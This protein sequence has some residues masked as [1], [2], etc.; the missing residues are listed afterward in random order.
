MKKQIK[1]WWMLVI[2]TI[3]IGLFATI[4]RAET[5]YGDFT[6]VEYVKNYDGDTITF[7]IKDVHPLIGENISVRV[8]GIDTPEIRGKCYNEKGMAYEGRY[9]IENLCRK[10]KKII[11]KNVS[12]GKYFRIVA[13]I[14]VDDV[15][16]A[17]VLLKAGLAVPYDGGTKTM[18]WCKPYEKE[19]SLTTP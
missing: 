3:C 4:S 13:D 17:D 11:L 5:T 19:K 6:N 10:G 2:F 7:N 1:I 9:I 12:R 14:Y 8:R 15:S 18:D 16:V